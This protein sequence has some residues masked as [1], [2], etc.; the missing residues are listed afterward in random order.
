VDKVHLIKATTVVKE[1]VVVQAQQAVVVE[2]EPLGG[3]RILREL[4]QVMAVLD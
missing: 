3:L 2:R 4:F 1:T